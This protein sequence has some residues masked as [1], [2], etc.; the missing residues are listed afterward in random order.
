MLDVQLGDPGAAI[1]HLLRARERYRSIGYVTGEQNAL[2]QLG[3]AYQ[4]VGELGP[5]MAAFDSSLALAREQGLRQE[6]ASSLELI[7]D[8]YRQA[9][10]YPPAL[11]LYDEANRINDELGL[12]VEKGTNRRSAAE[13]QVAMG[14]TD[15]AGRQLTEALRIHQATGARLQELR[16]RLMVAEL[17]SR[18]EDMPRARA[19]LREADALAVA[20]DARTARVEVAL[21]RAGVLER[22]GD[23]SGVLRTLRTARSDLSG[24]GYDA[25]WRA[26]THR[27]WAHARL[28]ELDSAANAG[29]EA[30]AAVERVRGSF[31]SGVLG[32]AFAAER[33]APYADLVDVLLRSGRVEE[34]FEV[35]DASRNQALRERLSATTDPAAPIRP[36]VSALAEGEAQL[37]AIDTLVSRLDVLEEIPSAERDQS[38][39]DLAQA[40]S[41]QLAEA[42]EAYEALLVRTAERDAAGT[43]MLG[44]RRVTADEVRAALQPGETLVE[45]FAGPERLV[46]FVVTR[47]T[48]RSLTVDVAREELA[49]QVRVA[50]DLLGR[51]GAS[52]DAEPG[53]VL[54]ALHERLI[55]PLERA[56]FLAG[57]RRLVLVPHAALVYLPAAALRN[58]A[59]RRYLVEDYALLHLPSSAALMAVRG[60]GVRRAGRPG[61]AFA[62]APFPRELPAAVEE[63]RA[64]RRAMRGAETRYGGRATERHLRQALAV[65]GVVHLATHG[66]MN[67][68]NPMF[69][70]LALA[71]GSGGSGDDGRLEVHELLGLQLS[72][73]LVFL[74]G[75]ETGVGAAWSTGFTRG[76]DYATLAQAFLY[77]GAR[78]VLATLWPIGDR[79]AAVFA[80]RFYAHLEELAPP[81]ALAAAQRDLLRD[82]DFGRPFHW[83]AYHLSGEGGFR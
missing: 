17:A 69:S 82:P 29:R 5:A 27:A 32:S 68:R 67:P 59:T 76:E 8:L 49:S 46:V 39:H 72:G 21:A 53:D 35:A 66:V 64:F 83:A 28:L 2:G 75:C 22:A 4:A 61:R 18:S 13:V 70:R 9:G 52:G 3:T 71:P 37:R 34:A 51:P 43:A 25:E 14:R 33:A 26:A 48:I 42:R 11:R 1:E 16:D 20:L 56:G 47:Q 79:G 24:G 58:P 31:R 60:L 45:Y 6:E 41:G 77:A 12:E 55:A 10:D 54:A 36:T 74:S 15:L 40:L 63:V 7:A 30:V 38:S 81:E 65:A 50:R 44:S 78:N 57:T 73:P 19:E 80:R 23:P 62:F